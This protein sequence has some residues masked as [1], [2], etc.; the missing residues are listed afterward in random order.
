[1]CLADGGTPVADPELRVDVLGVRAHGVER[2]HELAGDVG[3]VQVA[4]QQAEHVELPVAERVDEL[5][6]DAT[7]YVICKTGA[8][9]G[10]AVEF[11]LANGIDAVNIAGGTLAWREA[12][13][14][15]ESGS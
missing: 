8:R 10:R 5:P 2:H 11:L 6:T 14:P 4:G 7:V 13:N 1:M 9:S 3:A 12:G 15:V